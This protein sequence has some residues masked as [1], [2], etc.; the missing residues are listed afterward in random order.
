MKFE[1]ETASLN[2]TV[3][4]MDEELNKIIENSNRL[5]EAL[6]ALDGMWKGTAH[7]TFAAQYISDQNVLN[8]MC[9][10]ISEVIQGMGEARKTYEESEQSVKNEIRKIAI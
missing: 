5:Y 9:K 4:K 7:D 8:Q 10:T 3:G 1:V 6:E 2:T